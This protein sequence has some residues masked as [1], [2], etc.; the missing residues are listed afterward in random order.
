MQPRLTFARSK[1][2]FCGAF[3]T[4][5]RQRAA[6]GNEGDPVPGGEVALTLRITLSREQTERLTARTINEGKNL[7]ALVAEILEAA[8][9]PIR[10]R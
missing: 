4:P 8:Q 1:P 3:A 7:N 10:R 9:P 6:I 2:R 5:E